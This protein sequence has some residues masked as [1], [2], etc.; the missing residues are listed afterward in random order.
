MKFYDL[1]QEYQDICWIELAIE[2]LIIGMED[3]VAVFI[4]T[5]ERV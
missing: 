2:D 4:E 1:T 3:A 5:G